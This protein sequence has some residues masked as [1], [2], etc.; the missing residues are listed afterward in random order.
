M[1]VLRDRIPPVRFGVSPDRTR[2]SACIIIVHTLLI[3]FE[4][5]TGHPKT[6]CPGTESRP[7]IVRNADTVSHHTGFSRAAVPTYLYR[8]PLGTVSSAIVA[9]RYIPDRTHV[10]PITHHER[11]KG[12]LTCRRADARE[13]DTGGH[14]DAYRAHVY[15]PQTIIIIIVQTTIIINDGDKSDG[16]RRPDNGT[17]SHG[18]GSYPQPFRGRWRR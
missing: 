9:H 4:R 6:G 18:L 8:A 13:E 14:R 16:V 7:G 17:I 2:P 10:A 3:L 5:V 15:Y 1:E 11:G 12:I